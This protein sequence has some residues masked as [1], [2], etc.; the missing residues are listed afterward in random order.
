MLISVSGLNVGFEVHNPKNESISFN[1]PLVFKTVDYNSGNSYN[2]S[3][4]KF[5][6]RYPGLYFFTPTITRKPGISQ[7]YC[8]ITVNG[9]RL[10]YTVGAGGDLTG[11]RSG[12]TTLV[13][14]LNIGD[15]VYLSEWDGVYH[16][17]FD[18]QFSGVLI[19]PD[20]H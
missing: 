13:Q 2:V 6:C 10:V 16:M 3:T 15:E 18:S 20:L 11:Y 4:G 12:T 7:S 17:Y 8:S 14:H 1:S 9:K 19:Q 5:I